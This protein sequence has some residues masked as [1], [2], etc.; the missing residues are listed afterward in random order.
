[1]GGT[2]RVEGIKTSSSALAYLDLFFEEYDWDSFTYAQALTVSEMDSLAAS[3]KSSSADDKNTWFVCFKTQSVPLIKKVEGAK[4]LLGAIIEGYKSGDY[5]AYSKF[6]AYKRISTAVA[7]SKSKI[8]GS[9]EKI[10]LNAAKYGATSTEV[11]GLRGEIARI[12][13]LAELTLYGSIE[14]I[15]EIK[16]YIEAKN[17]KISEELASRGINAQGEYSRAK[18]LLEEKK[19]V[20]ALDVLRT[21]DGYLDS[22]D[23]IDEIDKYYLIFDVLKIEDKLYYFK[24]NEGGSCYNLH[25]TEKEKISDKVIIKDIKKIITNYADILYYVDASN[26]LKRFNLSSRK[27]EKLID[28]HGKAF[29]KSIHK[30]V[31]C[32]DGKVFFVVSISSE[33]GSKKSVYTLSLASGTVQ[34]LIDNVTEIQKL[35][36][37]KMIYTTTSVTKKKDGTE[38]KKTATAVLNVDTMESVDLGAKKLKVEGFV[39]NSVVYTQKSP[40]EFNLNLY[41]KAFGEGACELLIEKNILR[42]SD[43]IADKLFYYVGNA[44]NNVLVNVNPD[45][46][47]RKEWPLYISSLLFE[48]SD[49]LYFIRKVG[50]NAALCKA[51]MDGTKFTVIATDV[52]K[53]IEIKNGYLYY[54]SGDADLVK[55]RMDGSN[56]QELCSDVETV[57][58]VQEDKIVF[59]SVDG[60]TKV[61]NGDNVITKTVKSIY[62]VDFGGT[63]KRKLAYDIKA[64]EQYD[65]DTVYYVAAQEINSSYSEAR[66]KKDFLYSL[67]VNTYE[68]EKLLELEIIEKKGNGFVTAMVIMAIAL[69]LGIIG[70]ATEVSAIGVIGIVVAIVSG[71]V[72][73][74]IKGNE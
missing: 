68:V 51:R 12:G 18:E 19:Y 50:Y 54:I 48:Q 52:E 57:L 2:V 35:D 56:Y 1:M 70:F 41:S 34:H 17:A 64:A 4:A 59:V 58:S 45:G 62:A 5:D 27:E 63:G 28:E 47:D 44:R 71:I 7:N 67:N 30:E 53:F 32:Y 9:L 16:A 21:L 37:N 69:F 23:I 42:F 36:G 31:Y 25:L 49:W 73:V 24:K 10:V 74:T 29:V 6:D 8:V 33:T 13:E 66:E 40:N 3:L 38:V 20:E 15:P 55:I 61:Q 39:G 65:D 60:K 46:T 43:I 22:E 72:G 26:L 14:E 11:G